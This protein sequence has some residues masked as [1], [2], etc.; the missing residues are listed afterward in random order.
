MISDG[1]ERVVCEECGEMTVRHSLAVSGDVSRA[2]FARKDGFLRMLLDVE[3]EEED[4][5]FGHRRSRHA[6]HAEA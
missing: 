6:K 5:S 1:V 3:V 4:R 2:Q